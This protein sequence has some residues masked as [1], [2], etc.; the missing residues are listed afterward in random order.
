MRGDLARGAYP[1]IVFVGRKWERAF[2]KANEDAWRMILDEAPGLTHFTIAAKDLA[3][4]FTES[5]DGPATRFEIPGSIETPAVFVFKSEDEIQ[6]APLAGRSLVVF[7]NGKRPEGMS[8]EWV[9]PNNATWTDGA[10]VWRMQF[11]MDR[12]PALD[13]RKDILKASRASGVLSTSGAYIV[14]E[15]TAQEKMLKE[16]QA[17]ALLGGKELDFDEPPITGDAPGVLL[18]LG[19]FG[20]LLL[21]GRTRSKVKC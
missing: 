15:N 18:I 10:S 12:N 11:E 9:T 14:V 1:Q 8:G 4:F 21:V 19:C 6:L 5:S 16:K 20:F 2:E 13:L 3:A 17:Q 7:S